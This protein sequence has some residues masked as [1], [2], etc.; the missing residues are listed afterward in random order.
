VNAKVLEVRLHVY[1]RFTGTIYW[2][3]VSISVIGSVTSAG[4]TK[5]EL[6]T[7]YELGDN[8]PNPFN[9]STKIQVGIPE[10]GNTLI[11]IYNTLG[12]KVRTL[13]D[14]FHAA[15]RFE[16]TWDGKDDAGRTVGT[17][18]Y[19]YRLVSGQKS[20]VKKMILVK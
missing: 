6:P 1:A 19:L 4:G 2:D 8:Y 7:S 11:V 17:G 10:A 3:D 20:M 14:E 16:V 9:P 12:Q 13:T 18:V 5:D 15:G